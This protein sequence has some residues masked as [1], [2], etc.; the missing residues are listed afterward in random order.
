MKQTNNLS[1]DGPIDYEITVQGC[2]DETWSTWFDGLTIRCLDGGKTIMTGQM[3]D[4]PALY[5]ILKKIRDLGVVLVS[6][7]QLNID[8][9]NTK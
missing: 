4:Q 9:G 1:R 2:L 5:G 3:A 8:P 6:V 7:N